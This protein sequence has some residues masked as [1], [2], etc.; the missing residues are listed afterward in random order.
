MQSFPGAA[1][2][3]AALRA[4]FDVRSYADGTH[5]VDVTISNSLNVS[6]AREVAYGVNIRLAGAS[7]FTRSGIRTPGPNPFSAMNASDNTYTVANHGLA[8]GDTIRVTGGA[9][10]GKLRVVTH[11]LGV[12]S[13]KLNYPFE[14]SL[15]VTWEKL[16]FVQPYLTRWRG[17]FS[18]TGFTEAA[19]VPDVRPFQLANAFP[20]YLDRVARPSRSTTGPWFEP[21]RIGD[22]IHPLAAPGARPEIG[23]YPAWVAQY[24][25]HRGTDQRA[26]MLGMGGNVAGAVSLHVDDTDGSM[27]LLDNHPDFFMATV[28]PTGASGVASSGGL[29]RGVL[30]A[31]EVGAAH[32]PALSFV[33]YLFTGERFYLDEL[34]YWANA[35]MLTWSWER[36]GAAGLVTAQQVR[37]M[38]WGLRDLANAAAYTP[39]DDPHRAYFT[40]KTNNN[41]AELDRLA[42]AEPDPLGGSLLG[43]PKDNMLQVF[44]QSFA[45]WAF[46]HVG[47]QGFRTPLYVRR[48]VTYW[49]GL[50]NAHPS[51]DKRYVGS[52]QMLIFNPSTGAP[53]SSYGSLFD[54]NFNWRS[55]Q[56]WKAYP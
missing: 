6:T 55:Y 52:Y 29:D 49:N 39:D 42:L 13:V 18:T 21:F 47:K 36:K 40:E 50:Y 27:L 3:A 46:D 41:L 5:R 45:A 28:D 1:G 8:V 10:A 2:T 24:I 16:P 35:A 9:G 19:T 12:S 22:L 54:Y 37:S 31:P 15:P 11:V 33:P 32:T 23:L 17:T 56:P 30:Y 4:I 26:Y 43:Y 38:G 53:F 48:L 44:M 25:V 20:S 7:V 34:K 14:V 51:F